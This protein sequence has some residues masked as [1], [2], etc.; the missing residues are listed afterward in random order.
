[1][2]VDLGIGETLYESYWELQMINSFVYKHKTF[3][4]SAWKTKM[5]ML[6]WENICNRSRAQNWISKC[7]LIER[8]AKKIHRQCTKEYIWTISGNFSS[9]W[10]GFTP[11]ATCNVIHSILPLPAISLYLV[12]GENNKTAGNFK[13]TLSCSLTA[14]LVFFGLFCDMFSIICGD[15]GF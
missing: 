1:M 2:F 14:F 13:N 8:W 6:K 4:I 12:S 7:A 10:H 9:V 3:S 15:T 5:Q 11:C